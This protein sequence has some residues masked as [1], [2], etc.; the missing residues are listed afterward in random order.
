ML[1]NMRGGIWL[2]LKKSPAVERP[3][4]ILPAPSRLYIPLIQFM[5]I[6]PRLLIKKGDRVQLGQPLAAAGQG[7]SEAVHAPVSG[8][9]IDITEMDHPLCG[10]T[11]VVVLE[12]DER[13]FPYEYKQQKK[14]IL[15]TSG[16]EALSLIKKAS[17]AS[18]A[19]FDISLADRLSSMKN[20]K[21]ENLVLNAV[22]TEPYICSAQ[23]LLD[24]KPEEAAAG[25]LC[26]MKCTGAKNAVIAISHDAGHSADDTISAARMLG[27]NVRLARVHQKYPS[28]YPAYLL[29]L[30]TGKKLPEGQAVEG[31]GFGFVYA[32]EC[33]NVQKA[34]EESEP[35]LT[36]V[37]TVAG[38]A[39]GN[40]QNLE[41]KIG[42]TVKT[43]LE[44]CGMILEPE[45]VVL[46]SP[47]RGVAVSDLNI[48][49]TKSVSA[50]L[51]LTSKRSSR[52]KSICI[53]CGKCVKVCPQRLLP[54]YIAVSAVTADFEA[55]KRFEI[56]NCIECGSCAYI[57]PGRMP[58]VELI[59]K[60]K[61]AGI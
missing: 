57:C 58:I 17:I 8:A 35:Q 51:A 20:K 31:F 23:K 24:E 37:I 14:N 28:G 4:E 52:E 56:E 39:V 19:S 54:N 2:D 50:V 12:N 21:I 49:V 29:K 59:K 30:L 43:V 38:E 47:M 33:V 48:P 15:K 34:V 32:E 41:V 36:K 26:M 3:V 18:A 7:M 10:K 40:P 53:N 5:G 25:L 60:I 22:E 9:V 42:T 6:K 61:K 16:D 44:H 13:D 55:C 11:P 46:G 1:K 27:I 45:Q